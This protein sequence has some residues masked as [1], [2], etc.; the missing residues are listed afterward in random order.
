MNIIDWMMG[1]FTEGEIEMIKTE[2]R[3]VTPEENDYWLDWM[4]SN[5]AFLEANRAA[6]KTVL[7]LK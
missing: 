1:L 7:D 3:E 4:N 6:A 5:E 2:V